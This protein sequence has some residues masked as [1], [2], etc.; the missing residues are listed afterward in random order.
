MPCGVD[1][2]GVTVRGSLKV[3]ERTAI[4]QQSRDGDDA[5]LRRLVKRRRTHSRVEQRPGRH[6]P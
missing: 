6:R 1:Q 2:R 4:E 5:G 3:D